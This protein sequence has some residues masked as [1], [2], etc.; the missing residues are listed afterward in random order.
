MSCHKNNS[1]RPSRDDIRNNNQRNYRNEN[2]RIIRID[3]RKKYHEDEY[4]S[5]DIIDSDYEEN[6]FKKIHISRSLSFD[7][8]NQY[9]DTC[10]TNKS[11]DSC[12]CN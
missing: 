1:Y 9:N 3:R 10:K 2:E 6:E 7:N 12:K 4:N 8:N 11:I 5:D